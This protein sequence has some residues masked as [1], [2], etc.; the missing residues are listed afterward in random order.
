LGKNQD[1]LDQKIKSLFKEYQKLTTKY[2]SS[3]NKIDIVLH[4]LEKAKARQNTVNRNNDYI[5]EE[6]QSIRKSIGH[7]QYKNKEVLSNT[8][9]RQDIIEIKRVVQE[10]KKLILS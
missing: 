2:S 8:E 10:V 7:C 1:I 5:K 9:T 6:V 3:S 4:K